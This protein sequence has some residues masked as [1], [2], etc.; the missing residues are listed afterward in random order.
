MPVTM[1]F[2]RK[3]LDKYQEALDISNKNAPRGG[4]IPIGGGDWMD[5]FFRSEAIMGVVES[6]RRKNGSLKEA[7]KAGVERATAAI[8]IWNK[9]FA[10]FDPKFEFN[11]VD[12][13][14]KAAALTTVQIDHENGDRSDNRIANLRD[15][16]PSENM[17]NVKRHITNTSG[18]VGV[19]WYKPRN[20]WVARIT[21]NYT[22]HHLGYFTDIADAI[23][24]RKAA[25]IFYGFHKNHGRRT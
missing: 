24:A 4:A 21:V 20:K 2:R 1:T 9:R 14:D 16:P 11:F 6:L 8:E 17:R 25:E 12:C 10:Y 15:V 22:L 19:F 13:L 5:Y 3:L 7:T 23:A 18:H